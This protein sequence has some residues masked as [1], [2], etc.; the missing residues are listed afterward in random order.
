MSLPFNYRHLH[1]FWVVVKEGGIARAAERLDVAVQTVSAQVS[2]LERSLGFALL[3]SSGR[4]LELTEAGKEAYRHAETIFQLGAELA[5]SVRQAATSATRKFAVGIADGLPKAAV[6]RLLEPIS[7]TE[8]VHLQ[9]YEYGFDDMLAALALHRLDIVLADR[10]APHNAN[11][12]VFN[13]RLGAAAIEWYAAPALHQGTQSPFPQCL[14]ELPLLLPTHDMALR[15]RLDQWLEAE[16]L[17]P[18]VVG[19]FADSGLLA[20]FGAHGM[21]AFPATAWSRDE[22]TRGRGLVLLGASPDVSQQFYAI[23]AERKIQNPLIQTVLGQRF[24]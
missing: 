7:R 22:L 14:G 12:K 20:T 19:E 2:E 8:S 21:G 6:Q 23:S 9:A 5:A 1:Y 4:R 3:K 15:T 16:K 17:Q 24:E 13:H 10:P 11:L 18:R